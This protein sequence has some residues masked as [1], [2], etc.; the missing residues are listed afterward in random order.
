MKE[1][2]KCTVEAVSARISKIKINKNVIILI[3]NSSFVQQTNFD[4]K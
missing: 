2:P 4:E 1:V 3:K